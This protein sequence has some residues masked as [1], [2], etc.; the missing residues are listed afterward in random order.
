MQRIRESSDIRLELPENDALCRLA[1][2]SAPAR[3]VVFCVVP[4][5]HLKFLSF[6]IGNPIASYTCGN[7]SKLNVLPQKHSFSIEFL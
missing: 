4:A 3:M 5:R 2:Q 1:D 6:Y 7:F